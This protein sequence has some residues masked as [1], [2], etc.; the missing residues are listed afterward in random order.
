MGYSQLRKAG[1]KQF[2]AYAIK[3]YS[4]LVL[5]CCPVFLVLR[6]FGIY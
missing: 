1:L 4:P 3:C 6:F 2:A 5:M